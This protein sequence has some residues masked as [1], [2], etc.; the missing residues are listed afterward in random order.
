[1]RR[2][3]Y[4]EESKMRPGTTF[5]TGTLNTRCL[6]CI[7]CLADTFATMAWA[8]LWEGQLESFTVRARVVTAN[9]SNL[10]I[11]GA[12]SWILRSYDIPNEPPISSSRVRRSSISGRSLCYNRRTVSPNLHHP[13]YSRRTRGLI[14]IEE[15]GTVRSC[16][17]PNQYPG[18]N[19]YAERAI[20]SLPSFTVIQRLR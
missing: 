14:I 7:G 11:D 13:S 1:M 9:A 2:R 3:K 19:Q 10:C 12:Q 20:N 18:P 6:R 8:D 17:Y 4:L 5:D 15:W 16:H